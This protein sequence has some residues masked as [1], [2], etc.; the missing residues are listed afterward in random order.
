MR[1]AEQAVVETGSI[2]VNHPQS[3][4]EHPWMRTMRAVFAQHMFYGFMTAAK[5]LSARSAL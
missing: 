3:C 5:S 4:I 2:D 1:S